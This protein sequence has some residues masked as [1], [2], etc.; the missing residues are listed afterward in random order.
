ME[1]IRLDVSNKSGQAVIIKL[2]G[3]TLTQ[4]IQTTVAAHKTQPLEI[5]PGE[6]TYEISKEAAAPITKQITL[7]TYIRLE[8][9]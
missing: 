7:T 6:Y 8:I 3:P 4:T 1:T 9:D 2:A 5:P